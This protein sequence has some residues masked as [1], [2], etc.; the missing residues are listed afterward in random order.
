M[1]MVRIARN[2]DAERLATVYRA[3]YATAAELGFP[4]P[5]ETIDVETVCD[6]L[7]AEARTLVAT[8]DDRPIGTVRLRRDRSAA[9]AE[10]LAVDPEW[11]GHGVGDGLLRA[12]ETVAYHDGGRRLEAE[13]VTDHPFLR[14]WYERYGFRVTGERTLTD[15]PY[16]MLT[17]EKP[18]ESRLPSSPLP[19]EISVAADPGSGRS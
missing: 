10:R 16:D 9:H 7:G 5:M 8:V 4:S 2:D 17:M 14:R 12:I 19:Q 15:R 11:H 18:V 3:A 13:T 1:V 6:W